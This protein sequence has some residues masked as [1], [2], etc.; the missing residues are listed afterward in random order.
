[1]AR[2]KQQPPPPPDLAAQDRAV[3]ACASDNRSSAEFGL[4]TTR[5]VAPS[6][7]LPFP[8]GQAEQ[9]AGDLAP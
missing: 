4:G 7:A 1:M 8:A 9:R 5:T 3:E 2:R 6:V